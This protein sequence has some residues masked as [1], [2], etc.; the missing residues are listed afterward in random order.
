MISIVT[1]VLAILVGI[2]L[3]AG[4]VHLIAGLTGRWD[5]GHLFFAPVALSGAAVGVLGMLIYRSES[6]SWSLGLTV[7]YTLVLAFCLAVQAWFVAYFSGQKPLR[8]LVP[9]TLAWSSYAI[10]VAAWPRQP[11]SELQRIELPWGESVALP[12]TIETVDALGYPLGLVFFVFAFWA[13]SRQV[14]SG[15]RRSGTALIVATGVLFATVCVES[16]ADWAGLPGLFFSQF[17]FLA[18]V[19]IMGQRL[20]GDRRERG[21]RYRSIVEDQAEL[22]VRAQPDGACTFVN[23][24]FERFFETSSVELLGRNIFGR[25]LGGA[26]T[27]PRRAVEQLRVDEPWQEVEERVVAARGSTWLLWSVRKLFDPHGRATEIQLVARDVTAQKEAEVALRQSEER[28]ALAV[29]GS[30]DGIWDWDLGTHDIFYSDRFFELLGYRRGYRPA[31]GNLDLYR[32]LLH[33]DDMERTERAVQD[34]LRD[35]VPYDIEYRLRTRESGYRWFRSRGQALWGENGLAL[36]MSGSIQDVDDKRRSRVERE[37]LIEELESKNEELERLTYTVSHDLKSPL[38]TISGFAGH[39]ERDLDS[40]NT[41]RVRRDLEKIHGAA[42]HMRE[43]LD[44]LLVLSR[45]G[46]IVAPSRDLDMRS[47][48]E[49]ACEILA[50]RIDAWKGTLRI[51]PELPSAFGDEKRILEVLQNL[52]DNALR[53]SEGSDPRVEVSFR[54]QNGQ[55]EYLIVDN[56]IG[57]DAA[58]H[59]RIF[60]LFERLDT[61]SNGTGIGLAVVKRI[62]ELHGG[63]I[64]VESDGKGHGTTVGFTL[65]PAAGETVSVRQA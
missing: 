18:Y 42:D 40:G 45:V 62:V 3:H 50:G 19:V 5:E 39:I 10:A 64:W 2:C 41:D 51:D 17:G 58:Y 23:Q 49:Q 35:R 31:S 53:F 9:Y 43:L 55:N 52:I 27:E 37:S 8:F 47:L 34:H 24:A 22:I 36:R 56:G 48:T 61:D 46:R 7:S 33:P 14:R 13:G 30:T 57:I 29:A 15:D 12:T 11:V 26:L 6:P 21:L 32:D 63:K 54:R 4:F 38:V 44:D 65:S 20:L 16:A 25:F 59:E 1:V 60:Q 28:F